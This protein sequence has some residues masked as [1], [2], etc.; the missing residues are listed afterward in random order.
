MGQG[1]DRGREPAEFLFSSMV[2][3]RIRYQV[4]TSTPLLFTKQSQDT[5]LLHRAWA[6]VTDTCF[7]N[8]FTAA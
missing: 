5:S 3:F 4:R 8:G 2:E 7:L 6:A 1:V